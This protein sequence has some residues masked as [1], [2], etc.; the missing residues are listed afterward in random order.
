MATGTSQK[1]KA[2]AIAAQAPPAK[3]RAAASTTKKGP[4]A[5]PAA[6][7]APARKAPARKAAATKAKAPAKKGVPA[8]AA[9]N[10]GRKRRGRDDEG[11][12]ENTP[13]AKKAKVAER[14]PKPTI[15][16]RSEKK[17]DVY[18]F[19]DGASSELGLG[20]KRNAVVVKRP[21][22]NPNL[23]AE[24]VGVTQVACGGMHSAAITWD[25]QIVTWGVNDQKALGRDTEWDGRPSQDEDED[26]S[27]LNPRECVPAAIDA[28]HFPED[29]VF[30]KVAC[31][32]SATFVITDTGDVYGWGTFR[33]GLPSSHSFRFCI[34]D[35]LI[36]G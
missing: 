11:E 20:S 10:E 16:T 2:S 25:N 32:D 28:A 13:P 8:A 26:D 14:K 5:T 1:R 33:V 24:E 3:R 17:L 12:E 21:R 27:G 7:K 6:R 29:A 18:V 4:K 30:A 36:I 9:A 31:S 22:L 35:L 34:T 19:G 23:L 15:N